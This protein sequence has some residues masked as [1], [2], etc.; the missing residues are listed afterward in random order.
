M[1]ALGEAVISGCAF[2]GRPPTPASPRRLMRKRRF[3]MRVGRRPWTFVH[4]HLTASRRRPSLPHSV[5]R[6]FAFRL[7]AAPFP[8][9]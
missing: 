7:Y 2:G 6:G 1:T 4:P 3:A 9:G 5:F 8:G